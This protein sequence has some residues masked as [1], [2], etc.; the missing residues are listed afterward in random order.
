MPDEQY[1]KPITEIQSAEVVHMWHRTFMISWNAG[2]HIA[3]VICPV[4]SLYMLLAS[5]HPSAVLVVSL[6][7]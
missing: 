5:N 6:I 3:H 4:S 2:L 1:E 7:L